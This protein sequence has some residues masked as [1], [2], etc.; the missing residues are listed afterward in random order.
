MQQETT[1]KRIILNQ[2]AILERLGVSKSTLWRMI[3][4]GKFPKPFKLGERLNGW[5]VDVFENWLEQ[6]REGV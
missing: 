2:R 3:E 5:H 4:A 6:S 1:Q